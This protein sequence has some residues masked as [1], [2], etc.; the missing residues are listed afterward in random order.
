MK[1]CNFLLQRQPPTVNVVEN[2]T[3][4]LPPPKIPKLAVNREP[5]R[6]N[7]GVNVAQVNVQHEGRMYPRHVVMKSKREFQTTMRNLKKKVDNLGLMINQI[8]YEGEK[9]LNE[10][11]QYYT[12]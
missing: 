10:I 11:V 4:E 9:A 3:P 1:Q 12:I 7:R 2:D 6:S 8:S 5:L